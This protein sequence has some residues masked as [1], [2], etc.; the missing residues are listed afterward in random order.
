M[1]G[2][3]SLLLGAFLLLGALLMPKTASPSTLIIGTVFVLHGFYR[4]NLYFQA[5]KYKSKQ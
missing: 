3:I 1:W 4:F 5:K 2:I